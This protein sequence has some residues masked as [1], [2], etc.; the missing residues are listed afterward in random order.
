MKTSRATTRFLLLAVA[1]LAGCAT[2]PAPQ[3]QS[4]RAPNVDFAAF[5][6]FALPATPG[7]G[8]ND[9]PLQ[10]LDQNIRDAIA[11]Q[12]RRKGYV[13]AAEQPELRM[14]YETASA[15]R[16]EN[17]PVQLGIGIGGWGSNGGGSVSTG[18]SSVSTY[19]EG[20]LVIRAIDVARNAEVWVGSVSTKITGD[21][22]QPAAVTSVVAGVMREFPARPAGQ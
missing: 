1:V 21:S 4:Q 2:T 16:V 10:L 19:K 5:H 22:L 14:V 9:A 3:P 17:K 15:D 11:E 6:T 12:M 18:T 13:E 8:D 7:V 20:T